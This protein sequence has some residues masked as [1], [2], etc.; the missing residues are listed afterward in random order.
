EEIAFRDEMVPHF[1]EGDLPLP[2]GLKLIEFLSGMLKS[3]PSRLTKKMKHAKLSTRHFHL[4]GGYICSIHRAKELSRLELAFVNSI[5]DAV[6]RSE[7]KFHMQREWRDRLAERLTYL[8]ISFDAEEWLKSVDVMDRRIS[9][10]K[11]RNRMVKRRFMMGK[12]MEKDTSSPTPGIFIDDTE[13]GDNHHHHP[14]DVDF[15]LLASALEGKDDPSEDADLYALYSSLAA[16]GVAAD[17][18]ANNMTASNTGGGGQQQ[19]QHHHHEVSIDGSYSSRRSSNAS[20][21]SEPMSQEYHQQPSSPFRSAL[22]PSLG[23]AEG[24][25]FRFA[26]PFIAKI[27]AYIEHNRVPFEHVDI[28]VPSSCGSPPSKKPV[29]EESLLGSGSSASSSAQDGS[30][31]S[32]RLCFAGSANAGVQILPEDANTPES[33]SSSAPHVPSPLGYDHRY[34]KNPYDGSSSA[35]VVPLSSDEIYHLSLF[36]SYSE[37]FSFTSG[38]GLPGR[39]YES[40]VPAWEQF[41]ANAPA[42]L[43]ERRGGAM[44]FGIKTALGLPIKSPN[45]GRIVLVLYSKHNREKD[46]ELVARMVRDFQSLNPCPRW[47]LMVDM[48]NVTTPS[49]T[50]ANNGAQVQQQQQAVARSNLSQQMAGLNEKNI[51][52]T[53]LISLLGEN[54]PSDQSTPLGQQINNIMSLRMVLLRRDRTPQDEHLVD[55]ILTLFDSYVKAGRSRPDITLMLARDFVFHDSMQQ[56]HQ[57]QYQQPVSPLHQTSSNPPPLHRGTSLPIMQ[58]LSIGAAA[59]QQGD[60]HQQLEPPCQ[61]DHTHHGHPTTL[62]RRESCPDPTS[63]S[64]PSLMERNYSNPN[65]QIS[66]RSASSSLSRL[67]ENKPHQVPLA[68]P[69]ASLLS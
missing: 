43:F 59:I 56:Q 10:A 57:Q 47:K 62:A 19:Q 23:S 26:A 16:D 66:P 9:L 51:Q 20:P 14:N 5:S 4:D 44:Q 2:N 39:V 25:N 60:R 37:K 24:P 35:K 58:Q 31:S 30:T 15:E 8:R 32:E 34:S 18:A 53:S 54:M 12:A 52:I 48:G 36:G 68:E 49:L 41:I 42:H 69:P 6:E 64:Y 29:P 21:Y 22:L 28:W 65:L 38:Y 50:A 45:V 63:P 27:T 13:R 11:S 46:D 17:A 55:S 67:L 3:K 33:L 1:M 7:I 61:L 40:G